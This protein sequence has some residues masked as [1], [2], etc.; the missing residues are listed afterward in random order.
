[1]SKST[2]DL[3]DGTRCMGCSDVHGLG[4]RAR[5]GSRDLNEE[6]GIP[7]RGQSECRSR[8]CYAAHGQQGKADLKQARS[9]EHGA[10]PTIG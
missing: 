8:S 6:R 2:N 9:G 3:K 4:Y 1:M 7:R 10:V 5:P